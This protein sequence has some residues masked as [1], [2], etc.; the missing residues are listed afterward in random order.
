[1]TARPIRAWEEAKP[2]DA[3]GQGPGENMF[4]DARVA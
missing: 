4:L 2:N 1:V 3:A